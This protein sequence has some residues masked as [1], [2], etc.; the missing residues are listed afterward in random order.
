VD[1]ETGLEFINV[2]DFENGEVLSDDEDE[3]FSELG[4]NVLGIDF[5]IE[6]YEYIFDEYETLEEAKEEYGTIIEVF[7]DFGVDLEKYF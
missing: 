5:F 7:E 6:L 3:L 4:V 1:Y 2:I